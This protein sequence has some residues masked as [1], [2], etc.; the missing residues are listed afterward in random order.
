MRHKRALDAT[1]NHADQPLDATVISRRI[2]ER[3]WI[4]VVGVLVNSRRV[5]S[6]TRPGEPRQPETRDQPMD[7]GRQRW[8]SNA[9]QTVGDGR[10]ASRA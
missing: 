7:G 10:R 9:S 3:I 8:P 1:V 6:R 2:D 5:A 4:D